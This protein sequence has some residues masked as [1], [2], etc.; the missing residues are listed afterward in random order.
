MLSACGG[1]SSPTAAKSAQR[2]RTQAKLEILQPAANEVTGPNTTLVVKLIGAQVVAQTTGKLVTDK[3]H[4]HVS[5]DGQLVSMAYG[6]TQDLH[7]LKPGS[8]TVQAEFVA[9]DHAPFANRVVAQVL[10]TVKP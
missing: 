5:V 4:I 6:T 10:F 7:D 2:P 8:H 9:L 1:S 3:G